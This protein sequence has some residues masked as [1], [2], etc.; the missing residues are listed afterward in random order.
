[1]TTAAQLPAHGTMYRRKSFNCGCGKCLQVDR[2]YTSNRT[3]LIAY[4]RW[5]PYIDAEPA[6]QHV[7]MLMTYGIGWQRVARISGVANG[8]LSTLLY[9]NY[10]THRP[11]SKRVRTETA[12]KILSVRPT[13]DNIAPGQY[14][15]ATGTRRRLQ[16]LVAIGW[17]Q[18]RIAQE[19][20]SEFALVWAQIRQDAVQAATARAVKDL[21]ERLWNVDPLTRGVLSRWADTARQIAAKHGWVP[22]A[23]WDDDVIDS[24]GATP[25]M[26]ETTARYV[27]LAE[28]ALWL[29]E[30]GYSRQQIGERLREHPDYIAAAIKRYRKACAEQVAA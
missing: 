3:R 18:R 30:Q 21:Y 4:G 17:P 27:E 8:T 28:N 5:Q 24:P 19:L 29:M 26:G 14:V 2:E 13:F 12:D 25:D 9:G 11:P 7:R 16:A 6:R 15:D 22:P 20:G 10:K 1:M 23:A